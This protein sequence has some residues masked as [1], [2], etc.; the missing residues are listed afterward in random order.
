MIQFEK[1]LNR[2][3]DTLAARRVDNVQRMLPCKAKA[4]RV[5]KHSSNCDALASARPLAGGYC[6]FRKTSDPGR[7]CRSMHKFTSS[8]GRGTLQACHRCLLHKPVA[9]SSGTKGSPTRQRPIPP[10]GSGHGHALPGMPRK[11]AAAASAAVG[12]ESKKEADRP[13][14]CRVRARVFR[15][16]ESNLRCCI[17]A[18]SHKALT[19][20][21]QKLT[22]YRR[23]YCINLTVLLPARVCDRYP[24]GYRR[25]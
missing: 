23:S 8:N 25:Q 7:V 18:S 13:S 14:F 22:S 5:P 9:T 4:G 12:S 21:P 3:E 17:P 19:S 16:D 24:R 11:D 6:A 15:I 1:L 20:L 10:R 2:S